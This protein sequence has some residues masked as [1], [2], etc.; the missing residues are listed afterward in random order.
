MCIDSLAMDYKI[1]MGRRLR[2]AREALGLSRPEAA[3]GIKGMGASALG[4]YEQGTRYPNDVALFFRL[5]ERLNEPA[6][7]L[8]GLVRDPALAEIM[9]VFH[10]ADDR[11]R[12]AIY[13][14]AMTERRHLSSEAARGLG[15]DPAVLGDFVEGDGFQSESN[16]KDA[17]RAK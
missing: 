1:L 9:R 10:R 13:S 2:A 8:A 3:K 11:G 16:T 7:Y 4:N 14:A 5:E 17:A 12:N 6:G 15:P